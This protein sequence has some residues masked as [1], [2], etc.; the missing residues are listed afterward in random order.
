MMWLC[1]RAA[2]KTLGFGVVVMAVSGI[3][4]LGATVMNCGHRPVQYLKQPRMTEANA[5]RDLF[6]EPVNETGSVA[7]RCIPHAASTLYHTW[8]GSVPKLF[9]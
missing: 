6:K 1:V 5:R 3:A 2:A 4:T 8:N 9:R 7:D